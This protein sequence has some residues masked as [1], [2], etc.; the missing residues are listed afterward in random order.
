MNF[1]AE[2]ISLAKN[3]WAGI[4][5]GV[6]NS[7]C[8]RTAPDFALP[9]EI[10]RM[11]LGIFQQKK[12][13]GIGFSTGKPNFRKI[14]Q[15]LFQFLC[16]L[17]WTNIAPM[18]WHHSHAF[19][20]PKKE[21][22]SVTVA[23]DAQRTIHTLDALGKSFYKHLLNKSGAKNICSK[24]EYAYVK[25]RRRENAI[26]QQNVLSMR[27][28][29][30]KISYIITSYDM[31]NA[32]GSVHFKIMEQVFKYLIAVEDWALFRQRIYCTSTS[33]PGLEEQKA[34]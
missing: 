17:R 12:G 28:K 34:L 16:V 26:K 9:N 5:K 1:P 21:Q 8:R 6:R 18:S 7:K 29:S 11:F 13:S 19:S 24:Y 23:F 20:L 15:M 3:D 25:G 22:S 33:V 30:A 14:K 2:I 4:I 31:R 32:F 10:W 27:L